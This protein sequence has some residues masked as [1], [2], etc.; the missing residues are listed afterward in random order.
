MYA[1]ID[2]ETLL[3]I[4]T[5]KKVTNQFIVSRRLV[6]LSMVLT[7]TIMKSCRFTKL[8]NHSK[9]AKKDK[10]FFVIIHSYLSMGLLL[11]L[12]AETS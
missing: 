11:V 5:Y 6:T 3:R 1:T 9:V 2:K 12:A 8:R 10:Q 4:C 7:V